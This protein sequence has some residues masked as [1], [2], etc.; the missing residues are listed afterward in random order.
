VTDNPIYHRNLFSAAEF[1]FNGVFRFQKMAIRR[2]PRLPGKSRNLL[3]H[4]ARERDFAGGRFIFPLFGFLGI[5]FDANAFAIQFGEPNLRGGVAL[6]SGFAAPFESFLVVS[7]RTPAIPAV[8]RNFGLRVGDPMK[9]GAQ[10]PFVRFVVRLHTVLAGLVN[11]PQAVFTGR[12]PFFRP[13]TNVMKPSLPKFPRQP[14][15]GMLG[16]VPQ[17]DTEPGPNGVE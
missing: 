13:K 17:S 15:T 8:F 16:T 14:D 6:F 4:R 11:E 1:R 2:V 12:I 3:T 9:S 7:R 5:P 10:K